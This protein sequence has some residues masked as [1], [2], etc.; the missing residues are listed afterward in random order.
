MNN[1]TTVK[2]LLTLSTASKVYPLVRDWSKYKTMAKLFSDLIVWVVQNSDD[3]GSYE[4]EQTYATKLGYIQITV[5][6]LFPVKNEKENNN[7]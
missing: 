2:L 3:K 7:E 1:K 5:N 4:Y 6:E